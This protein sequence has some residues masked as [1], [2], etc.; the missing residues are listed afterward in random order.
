MST[1]CQP[2]FRSCRAGRRRTDGW[3]GLRPKAQRNRYVLAR[4]NGHGTRQPAGQ[5]VKGNR[6]SLVT[7]IEAMEGTIPRYSVTR[8]N[9]ETARQYQLNCDL[10]AG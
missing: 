9:A 6:Q 4:A 10:R 5:G 8:S 2:A 7:Q 3:P 1:A